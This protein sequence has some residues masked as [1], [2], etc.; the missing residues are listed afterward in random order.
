MSVPREFDGYRYRCVVTNEVGSAASAAATLSVV[1]VG[2]TVQPVSRTVYTGQDATFTVGAASTPPPPAVQWQISTDGGAFFTNLAEAPPYSGTTS[3]TLTVTNVMPALNRRQYRA[4]ASSGAAS[5]VSG[6][7]TLI[8]LPIG[9][10][11]VATGGTHTCGLTSEGGLRCWGNNFYGQ[12][13]DGTRDGSFGGTRAVPGDVVG[14]TSGVIAV[15][16]GSLHTCAITSAGGVKCWGWNRYGQLGDNTLAEYRLTPVDVS[17]LT[18]GVIA[19]AAGALHTCAVTSTGAVKCWGANTSGRLGDG[20]TTDRRTPVDVVGLSSGISAV[21]TGA[22]HTCALS[23][24]G[25]VKCWGSNQSG[26]LGNG[27]TSGFSTT[28]VNVMGLSSGVT[29]VAAGSQHTC[30]LLS[31]GGVKCWGSGDSFQTGT[32]VAAASWPTPV[33]VV[34]LS[35]GV[36]AVAAGGLH[37]CALM[38]GG[39]AKCWGGNTLGQ[40]GDGTLT[41]R[42]TPVDVIGLPGGLLDLDVEFHS[43]VVTSAGQ[44]YCW[45]RGGFGELGDGTEI[46]SLNH[47]VPGLVL[48]TTA[49]GPAISV[50]PIDRSVSAGQSTTFAV[51]AP[52][53]A[54]YQWLVS[55]A[56]ATW[57][58]PVFNTSSGNSTPYSGAATATLTVTNAPA[59]LNGNRYRCVVANAT[60]ILMSA[61]ATLIVTSP[62][63]PPTSL[64][65]SSSGLERISLTWATSSTA[66]SYTIKRGTISGGET[67]L[68]SVA[69]PSYFDTAVAGG[70][71]YYYVVTAV[72][73]AGASANSNEASATSRSALA[74]ATPLDFDGD[75]KADPTIFRASSGAWIS[76]MTAFPNAPGTVFLGAPG[77]VPA[78]GDY[79]GDTIADAAIYRPSSGVWQILSSST[80]AAASIQWGLPGDVPVPGDYDGDGKTDPAVY[81]P[82]GGVWYILQSSTGASFVKQWGL[83]GDVPVPADYDGDGS[84][85][86]TVYRPSGAGWYILQSSTNFTASLVLNLGAGV[87]RP[88]PGDYDG[89]GR[90][91]PAVYRP[92]DQTWRWLRSGTSYFVSTPVQWGLPL[93]APVPADYDGDG[94]MD[95][96]VYRKSAGA[97]FVRR[98][99]DPSVPFSTPVPGSTA[100][101][102]SLDVALP[103]IALIRPASDARRL[104]DVDG[105][106]QSDLTVF[107]PGT[108]TWYSLTSSSGYANSTVTQWGLE[109]DIP[110]AGDYDGDGRAD[111]AVFRPPTGMW[112]VLTSS[113]GFTQ[114]TATQWGLPSDTPVPGDYDGDGRTDLAVYRPETGYWHILTSSSNYSASAMFQWGLPSDTPVPNDYDGDGRT[115]LAAYRPQAGQWHIL[116]S[117]ANFTASQMIQWD[118]TNDTPVS[119]DYDGDGKA[120]PAVFR[121]SSAQWHILLSSSG[122]TVFRSYE[123]GAPGDI[124]VPGDYDGDGMTDVA[125]F[126]PPT[127]VWS[128]VNSSSGDATNFTI[129]WGLPPDVPIAKR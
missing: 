55:P 9:L 101:D 50:Q 34:G 95:V 27:E 30:A 86:V 105:D 17:G 28:P 71:T 106:G 80:G 107:R 38:I 114:F 63:A 129:Q 84:M 90:A 122:Y 78:S 20:T 15:T 23:S 111:R 56:G 104:S 97:W 33:D 128:V 93:D 123:W 108:G 39:G 45:G 19:V 64:V 87:D 13:G 81:R 91:E 31:G 112:Y 1:T 26:R 96:A 99:S 21:A 109:G 70:L 48:T 120:D 115:D 43:C 35:S 58:S 100:A 124:A 92:A 49:D 10:T 69:S 117:S 75:G 118:L 59:S 88:V 42:S 53:A 41:T 110:V 11:K 44:A 12:I 8:V 22:E 47:P 6:A 60:G 119:G 94:M 126:H 82:S 74:A 116:L 103:V 65:A 79:D 4:V 14:L 77:D 36:A 29:A 7:A 127:G 83:P 76:A 68:A 3:P 121:S 2:I 72:N 98:S 40:L 46:G 113:S 66:A 85:D 62:P 16:A 37:T 24:G 67:T 57:W 102:T 61:P 32:G 5:A 125:V 73:A 51:T 54:R 18:S 89:D 25:G 52:S